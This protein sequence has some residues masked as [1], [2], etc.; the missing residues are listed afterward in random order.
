M[1][2]TWTGSPNA[3][4]HNN[5]RSTMAGL[6]FRFARRRIGVPPWR[7]LL[8]RAWVGGLLLAVAGRAAPVPANELRDRIAEL[9]HEKF[10]VREAAEKQLINLAAAD[11][12]VVL[13]ECARAYRQSRDPEVLVR[14]LRVMETVVDQY[15]F[16]VPRGFLG[17]QL[18]YV[19]AGGVALLGNGAAI[20]PGAVLVAGVVEDTGAQKAGLQVNDIILSLDARKCETGAAGVTASI[21]MKRPG[22]KIQLEIL[23]G[24]QTNHVEAVLG[25]MPEAQQ[26]QLLSEE[27]RAAFFERWCEQNLAP[28]VPPPAR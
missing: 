24:T 5:Q 26:K 15:L 25:A 8:S 28:S 3:M 19:F 21:Q 22:D 13:A 10:A 1:I 18:N 11:H 7:R 2:S 14:L 27:N 12:T 6:N 16:P 20:P 17:V 4:P 23:R 9:G